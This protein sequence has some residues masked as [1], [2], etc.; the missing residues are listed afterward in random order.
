VLV[1]L[2]YSI[3]KCLP[4]VPARKRTADFCAISAKRPVTAILKKEIKREK[5][6][7]FFFFMKTRVLV[8]EIREGS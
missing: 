3:Q 6:I 7:N 8:I 2:L 4:V 1:T 5:E